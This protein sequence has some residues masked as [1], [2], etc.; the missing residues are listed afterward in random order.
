MTDNIEVDYDKLEEECWQYID[1]NFDIYQYSLLE[2]QRRLVVAKKKKYADLDDL[3][4]TMTV[5][6][7]NAFGKRGSG[8]NFPYGVSEHATMSKSKM[9]MRTVEE[10]EKELDEI[11]SIFAEFRKQKQAQKQAGNS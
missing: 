4:Y 6:I 10:N 9:T 7:S 3:A 11:D 1:F 2:V 5:A 8:Y